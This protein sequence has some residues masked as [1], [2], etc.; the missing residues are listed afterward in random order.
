MCSNTFVQEFFAFVLQCFPDHLSQIW[1]PSSG[2]L[3]RSD[4]VGNVVMGAAE[5]EK[6]QVF[7]QV[8]PHTWQDKQ[9]MGQ[10]CNKMMRTIRCRAPAAR[11]VAHV[12]PKTCSHCLMRNAC[13]QAVTNRQRGTHTGTERVAVCRPLPPRDGSHSPP[14]RKESPKRK[15]EK[16]EQPDKRE[17]KK[18]T[19]Q[20]AR[21]TR[22]ARKARK[23]RKCP[24]SA[25]SP[26][27]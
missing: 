19:A 20:R 7:A 2:K 12:W 21:K 11:A 22:R 14:A 8:Q 23:A 4:G 26:T 18:R 16:P 9:R 15:P 27:S 13:N 25:K 10:Q 1:R 6:S 24:K 17:K 5:R 3:N